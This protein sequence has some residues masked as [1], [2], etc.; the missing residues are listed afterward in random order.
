MRTIIKQRAIKLR[1]NGYLYSEIASK[2]DVSKSTAHL[3]TSKLALSDLERQALQIKLKNV[4]REH[5]KNLLG[6][7]RKLRADKDLLVM[8]EAR[9]VVSVAKT[10]L[11]Y[12]KLICAIL[13]WCEGGKDTGSGVKFMNSDPHMVKTFLAL[14]RGSF[15]LKDNKFRAL[16]HLHEYHDPDKQMKFWSNVT[17]IPTSQFNRPYLK[18]HTGKNTRDG[19]PGCISVRYYDSSIGKLL[20]MIYIEFGNSV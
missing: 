7:N 6:I 12:K 2:L 15:T 11:E 5:A 8:E 19:Y 13:F 16:I 18:P 1:K 17:G 10:T 9:K 20:K 14:F 4:K 3:W